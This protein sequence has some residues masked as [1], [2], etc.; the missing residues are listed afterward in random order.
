M[1]VYVYIYI[2]H[3]SLFD[4]SHYLCIVGIRFKSRLAAMCCWT[5]YCLNNCFSVFLSLCKVMSDKRKRPATVNVDLLFISPY[6][7]SL[8]PLAIPLPLVPSPSAP[9][10]PPPFSIP[11]P[12][13]VPLSL[14]VSFPLP[15]LLLSTSFPFFSLAPSIFPSLCICSLSHSH[16][17]SLSLSLSPKLSL[18]LSHSPSISLFLS[19][20]LCLCSPEP[21][22]FLSLS[23]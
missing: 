17:P 19:L 3:V 8:F 16:F 10:A 13:S 22:L 9:S 5:L 15:H 18:H 6:L 20:S 21:P 23:L 14:A 11:Q 12:L 4:I 7:Q 2:K 1:L